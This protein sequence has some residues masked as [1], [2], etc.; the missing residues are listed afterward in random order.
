MVGYKLAKPELFKQMYKL[1]WEQFVPF[2]A[3]IIAI[4]ATDLLKGITIG[5]LIGLFYTLRHSYRN[6]HHI[7]DTVT[8]DNGRSVHHLVLAEEVSFFNKAN[9][10]TTLDCMPANSKV[11]IDFTNSKSIAYDVIELIRDFELNAKTKGIEL[12]KINFKP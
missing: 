2:A 1:G 7:K 10:L 12:V 8:D 11:I 3:T 6:S 4:V 5:L 9:L